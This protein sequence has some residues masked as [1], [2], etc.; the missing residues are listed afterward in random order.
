MQ[1]YGYWREDDCVLDIS[2]ST[3]LFVTKDA[4][5]CESNPLA[6]YNV[7]RDIFYVK[8]CGKN[9]RN[10]EGDID[11]FTMMDLRLAQDAD[12][13]PEVV[14][15]SL[16]ADDGD[17]ILPKPCLEHPSKSG[18]IFKLYNLDGYDINYTKNIGWISD[19][20]DKENSFTIQINDKSM[21]CLPVPIKFTCNTD[22]HL[23]I[24]PQKHQAFKYFTLDLNFFIF[25]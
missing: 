21:E 12:K 25:N 9:D 16:S 7:D 19:E 17:K 20:I 15:I 5:K 13:K 4:E 2:K 11:T 6:K 24:L 1:K 3:A 18:I 8:R 14:I 10:L 23:D 22:C